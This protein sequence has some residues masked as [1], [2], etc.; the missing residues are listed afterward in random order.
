M[1]LIIHL[2]LWEGIPLFLLK[3]INRKLFTII[4]KDFSS[5]VEL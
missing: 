4:G 3:K 5:K 1:R 2:V